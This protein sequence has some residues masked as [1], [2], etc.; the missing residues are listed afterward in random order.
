MACA[1]SVI[2]AYARRIA[3]WRVSRTAEARCVRDA[4]EPA[5]RARGPATGGGLV[6]HGDRG[7]RYLSLRHTGCRGEAGIAP[8]AGSIRDSCDT[9][10]AE[11][12]MGLCTTES[13][14]RRGPWRSPEAVGIATAD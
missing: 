9:A 12:A 3:G 4:P 5:I 13:P 7:S 14:R 8:S 10:P 6:D 2:D 1:A 11:T